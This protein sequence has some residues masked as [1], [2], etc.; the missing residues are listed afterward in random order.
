LSAIV[1]FGIQTMVRG[2]V[3]ARAE[4]AA[5][6]IYRACTHW[7]MAIFGPTL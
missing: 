1:A 5:Y 6:R 7:I 4:Q 2:E 3:H